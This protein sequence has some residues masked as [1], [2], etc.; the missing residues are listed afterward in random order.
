M[1]IKLKVGIMGCG[2]IGS[3]IAESCLGDLKD[4]IELIALFDIDKDKILVLE[5]KLGRKLGSS[6]VDDVFKKSELVIEAASAAISSEMLSHAIEKKVDIMIMSVG[7]LLGHE[8]LIK[9]ARKKGI[10]VYIPSGAVAGI[11]AIKAA[12]FSKIDSVTITTRKPPKGLEG[13]PYLLENGI[14]IKEIKEETVIF[15]GSA[16]QAVKGF[17]KNI[18]VSALLSLVGI[19]ADKTTVRIVTSPLFTRNSHEVEVK[20]EFGEIKTQTFNVPSPF[21]PK[22]SYLAILSAIATLKGIVDNVR[23]GT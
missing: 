23:M 9:E 15:E 18:N 17:P 7:G 5:N 22:T 19:G 13:A 4:S 20:G 6:S 10:R 3:K 11:D 2:V 16:K 21:N 1:E 12:S 8:N 14:N